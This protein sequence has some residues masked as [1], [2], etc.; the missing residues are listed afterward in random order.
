MN[1]LKKIYL[2]NIASV[3]ALGEHIVKK[4]DTMVS[5]Y[6]LC[7]FDID[8]FVSDINKIKVIDS[9]VLSSI[10]EKLRDLETELNKDTEK[11]ETEPIKEEVAKPE[12][13]QKPEAENKDEPKVESKKD[14]TETESDE[15]ISFND[16]DNLDD[17]EE[18]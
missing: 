1:E 5:E 16:D 13:E 7:D 3:R 8:T 15:E 6:Q 2:E 10:C 4:A 12:I 9:K 18:L 11:F 14:D 17:D